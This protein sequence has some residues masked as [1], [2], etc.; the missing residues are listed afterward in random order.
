MS[1][2]TP[3]FVKAE[4]EKLKPRLYVLPMHY[5]VPGFDEF[6]SP[7]EFLD[8]PTPVR[9]TPTTNLLSIPADLKADGPTVILLNWTTPKK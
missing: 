4:F 9:K 3:E 7:E 8:G 1:D 2:L 5:G 6:L